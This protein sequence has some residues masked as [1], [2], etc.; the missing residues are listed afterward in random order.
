[1]SDQPPFW[2]PPPASPSA[3]GVPT[4]RPP[5]RKVLRWLLIGLAAVLAL[6]VVVGLTAFAPYRIASSAMAPTLN[7]AKGPVA[8][9]CRGD[10]SDRVL[11]CRVCIHFGP[12]SRG[13]IVVFTTPRE[14][15]L[16]CGE[17]GTF[18][19]RVIGLPG[20]TVHEDNHGFIW[21]K[22]PGAPTFV[23]LDEPYLSRQSR[24]AD[25]PHFG[26][27]WSVPDGEYFVLGDNRAQ[28]CD[29]RT[30]GAVPHGNLTGSVVFRYWPLSR[31]GFL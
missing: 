31:L 23:K 27:T 24:L 18:V 4:T 3:G 25:S 9:G 14:A 7:C 20:E 22:R 15:A 21:I 1:M 8:V 16:K 26:E 28:S 29:S 19:K 30:W 13:D 10:S 12:P 5:Q 2:P 11:A 6:V 17:G